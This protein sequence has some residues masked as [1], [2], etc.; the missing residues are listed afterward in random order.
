MFEIYHKKSKLKEILSKMDKDQKR[1]L[2]WVKMKQKKLLKNLK[3]NPNEPV[4]D[5]N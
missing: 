1:D 5:C 4:P 2:S 3:L